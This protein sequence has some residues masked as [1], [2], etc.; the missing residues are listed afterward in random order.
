MTDRTGGCA[1]GAIRFK[2]T[3]P[4]MAVG[5]CHC[6]DCQK[7]SGGGPNYVALAPKTAFEVTT[8]EARI[9]FSKSDSGED[10]GRSVVEL[11]RQC[12]VRDRQAWCARPQFRP[13]AG[14]ASIY[15]LGGAVAPDARGGADISQD[16]AIPPA[17]DVTGANRR[18]ASPGHFQN[19]HTSRCYQR[20]ARP[21]RGLHG[22][23]GVSSPDAAAY[24]AF[25][26]S[27]CAQ[28]QRTLLSREGK[29]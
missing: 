15:R 27:P 12:A 8:G 21:A 25:S 14:P 23:F 29:G 22:H 5:V 28:Q 2:I 4:L 20:E 24:A 6:T 17:W 11:A 1:C 10:A 3:A 7:A 13:D 16:A 19:H 18:L 9:Y 26:P